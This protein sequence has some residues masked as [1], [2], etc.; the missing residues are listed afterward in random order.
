[1]LQQFLAAFHASSFYP[2]HFI[3]TSI[4]DRQLLRY[5]PPLFWPSR[6]K[7]EASTVAPSREDLTSPSFSSDFHTATAI[8]TSSQS[9]KVSFLSLS[10]FGLFDA[11]RTLSLFHAIPISRPFDTTFFNP[12]DTSINQKLRPW[13]TDV[14]VLTDLAPPSSSTISKY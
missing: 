9:Q 7:F 3:F 14:K 12:A 13:L 1:M 5:W 4:P 11:N 8:C 6:S 2:P 10:H